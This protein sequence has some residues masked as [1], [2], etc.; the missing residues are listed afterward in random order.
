MSVQSIGDIKKLQVDVM[1][2]VDI[3]V[4]TVRTPVPQKEIID[5]LEKKGAKSYSVVSA[6]NTLMRKGYLKKV[7][8]YASVGNRDGNKTFYKQLR[9]I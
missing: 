1:Q 5:R 3:W 2:V 7:K 6:L 4:H 8:I 9:G